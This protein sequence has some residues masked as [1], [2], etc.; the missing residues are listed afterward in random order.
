V[1]QEWP[2]A[3]QL[4]ENEVANRVKTVLRRIHTPWY[5]YSV[6]F[7]P[8]AA[9]LL[10]L[11]VNPALLWM[12]S[13]LVFILAICVRGLA[14]ALR[15]NPLAGIES[16]VYR[17]WF[18]ELN[19]PGRRGQIV[20]FSFALAMILGASAARSSALTGA[21]LAM[22]SGV[23]LF[24]GLITALFLLDVRLLPRKFRL[25]E[26]HELIGALKN[27]ATRWSSLLVATIAI[28]AYP[29][30]ALWPASGPAFLAGLIWTACAGPLLIFAWLE[31]RTEPYA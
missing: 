26:D 13:L 17:P 31:Y 7:I 25:I 19:G 22:T 9:L 14:L 23:V 18:R 15:P 20:I 21:A 8:L 5:F 3:V 16:A 28:A 24:C 29:A 2:V 11:P 1:N 12:G 30:Q 4:D 27:R 10:R 6:L